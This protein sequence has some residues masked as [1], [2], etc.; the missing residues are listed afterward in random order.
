[1]TM[2]D[3]VWDSKIGHPTT[4]FVYGTLILPIFIVAGLLEFVFVQLGLAWLGPI[5][6]QAGLIIAG[7]TTSDLVG[8]LIVLK[9]GKGLKRWWGRAVRS[10][11]E[12][13]I[14]A[15]DRVLSDF[16]DQLAATIKVTPEDKAR[17][18]GAKDKAVSDIAKERDKRK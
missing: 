15:I 6:L 18:L 7:A 12:Y 17:L 14:N 4:R 8:H 16:V 10:E 1:M 9:G 13:D 3:F 5:L 11:M 2:K